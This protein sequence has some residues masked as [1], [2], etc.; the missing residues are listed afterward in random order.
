M[1]MYF[2]SIQYIFGIETSIGARS[3]DRKSRYSQQHGYVGNK[4][5]FIS[6]FNSMALLGYQCMKFSENNGCSIDW[7]KPMNTVNDYLH[8]KCA[9]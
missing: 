9:F 8:F 4:S 2:F 6:T 7:N 3:L 1:C 5:Y